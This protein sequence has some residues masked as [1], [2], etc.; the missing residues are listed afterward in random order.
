MPV[1]SPL[2]IPACRTICLVMKYEYSI[3]SGRCMDS[4]YTTTGVVSMGSISWPCSWSGCLLLL[5][6]W[7]ELWS[8][9]SPLLKPDTIPHVALHHHAGDEDYGMHVISSLDIRDT[10]WTRHVYLHISRPRDGLDVWL[11]TTST[12]TRAVCIMDSR[13]TS[14]V[15]VLLLLCLSTCALSP[16]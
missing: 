3:S 15:A 13:C 8:T 1:G 7:R 11:P 2:G 9:S 5:L 16:S 10:I 6:D 4:L 14:I 12:S